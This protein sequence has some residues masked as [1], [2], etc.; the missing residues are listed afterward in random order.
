MQITI[1]RSL[2]DSWDRIAQLA[3][4]IER[5]LKIKEAEDENA[6]HI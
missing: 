3:D 2:S 6:Q 5:E 1:L 4:V